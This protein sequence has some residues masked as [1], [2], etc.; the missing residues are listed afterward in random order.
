[1]PQV[2]Q[3]QRRQH[4]QIQG[5]GNG[6]VKV[7]ADQV[8]QLRDLVAHGMAKAAAAKQL[9]INVNTAYGILCGRAWSW[10]PREAAPV[11]VVTIPGEDHAW[12]DGRRATV[13]DATPHQADVHEEETHH[14]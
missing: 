5:A 12:M 9:G 3:A 1:M 7:T 11:T 10:L 13:V 6:N 14:V 8:R 2:H 4:A